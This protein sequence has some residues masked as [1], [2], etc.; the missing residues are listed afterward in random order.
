MK[1]FILRIFWANNKRFHEF[2]WLAEEF[3]LS[4][5]PRH[6]QKTKRKETRKIWRMKGWKN[7]TLVKR[8]LLKFLYRTKTLKHIT[9][10]TEISLD[11]FCLSLTYIWRHISESLNKSFE[12]ENFGGCR[13]LFCCSCLGVPWTRPSSLN[14]LPSPTKLYINHTATSQLINIPIIIR[15]S[16]LRQLCGVVIFLKQW[17]ILKFHFSLLKV[18]MKISQIWPS[19]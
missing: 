4:L 10:K 1:V 5:H 14:L 15:Y 18:F 3:Q 7:R 6:C 16:W 8:P 17:K 11:I 2:F 12:L 13:I 19:I 9:I